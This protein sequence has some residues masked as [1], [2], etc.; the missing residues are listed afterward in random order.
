MQ[1]AKGV[2]KMIEK[3]LHNDILKQGFLSK[4]NI[5]KRMTQLRSFNHQI[6]VKLSAQNSSQLL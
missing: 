3:T 5:T 2:S 4:K 6:V 1:C